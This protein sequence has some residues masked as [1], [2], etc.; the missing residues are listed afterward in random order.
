MG[1]F[2]GHLY[3]G[4]VFATL[5]LWWTFQSLNRYFRS[6]RTN[7]YFKSSITYPCTC[8]CGKLKRW[9]VESIIKMVLVT[10]QFS[11]EMYNGIFR[12]CYYACATHA[13]MLF[14]FILGSGVEIMVHFK[15]P[16]PKDIEYLANVLAVVIEGMMFKLHVEGTNELN[17]RVHSL[18][19]Y[20]IYACAIIGCLEM[21]YRHSLT[22]TICRF[23]FF[24][25]QGTW[26]CQMALIL[27]NPFPNAEKWKPDDRSQH[28]LVGMMFAWHCAAVFLVM[29]IIIWGM[30]RRHTRDVGD[31]KDCARRGLLHDDPEQ[32][33]P[34]AMDDVYNDWY[35]TLWCLSYLFSHFI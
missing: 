25:L 6:L 5:A 7:T 24:F 12:G 14:F 10:L 28:H 31:D 13:T 15:V 20:V 3:P 34:V 33:T 1:S 29:F 21:K 23:Y 2:Q 4:L 27:Y 26:L 11:V 32:Q 17:V 30:W 22:V 8:L 9:P 16:L 35:L 19:G 18:L